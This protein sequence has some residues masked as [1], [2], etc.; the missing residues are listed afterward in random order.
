MAGDPSNANL[1]EDAN[2][3]VTFVPSTAAVPADADTAFSSDWELVGLLDGDQGFTTARSED[4][5]QR[6][7]WGRRLIKT[8]RRNFVETK[9]FVAYEYNEAVQRLLYPGSDAI[10][11]G[12][13]NLKVPTVE[14]V[15]IAFET[16]ED[17]TV[18]RMISF[19]EAEVA[20]NGDLNENEADVTGY[21][22]LATIYPG[23]EN[24]D[25]LW[26]EQISV[27]S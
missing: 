3:Y 9:S 24:V 17:D 12:E 20:L 26:I 4:V 21:P 14:R 13:R 16:I 2:V 19:F 11:G 10:T 22:F 18:R 25:T 23:G 5:T 8:S 6:Y 27:G 7:A 15:G 1:W